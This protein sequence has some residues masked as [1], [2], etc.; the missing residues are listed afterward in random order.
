[1]SRS[2]RLRQADRAKINALSK[3][4]RENTERSQGDPFWADY[5]KQECVLAQ[6]KIARLEHEL[7]QE[8]G[9]PETLLSIAEGFAAPI[10][11]ALIALVLGIGL[12]KLLAL[13]GK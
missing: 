8:R 2:R 11:F 10:T 6:K 3:K 7:E 9:R 13:L 1:M 4:L 5:W 12:S